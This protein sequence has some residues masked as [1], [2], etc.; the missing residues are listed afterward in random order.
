MKKSE[1][2]EL[3]SII[4]SCHQIFPINNEK[5]EVWSELLEDVSYEQARANLK[6]H[7]K[8]SSRI[9]TPADLIQINS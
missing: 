9:P 3:F 4:K 8:I 7:L 6:H 1:L 5:I 2:L